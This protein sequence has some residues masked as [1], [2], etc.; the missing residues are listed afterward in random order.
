MILGI[1][2]VGVYTGWALL[3]EVRCSFVDLGVSRSKPIP[4][5]EMTL[6]IARDATA[7]AKVIAAKAP[8]C[9]TIVVERLGID[10]ALAGLSWGVVLGVAATFET[11]PRLLT[12]SPQQWQ[13]EVLPSTATDEIDYDA[14]ATKA[15]GFVLSRHPRAARALR[16]VAKPQ[17]G[18][19]IAAAMLALVGALRPARCERID[20]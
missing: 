20:G 9:T 5:A 7:Q 19:A 11:M 3:D 12:I 8:G 13:R 15:G 4:G 2:T 17:H 18:V 6:A 16:K 14:L 1:N 10:A